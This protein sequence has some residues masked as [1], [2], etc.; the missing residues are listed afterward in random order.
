MAFI[1]EKDLAYCAGIVDGEGYLGFMRRGRCF[2]VR[3]GVGNTNKGLIDW[4]AE[5]FDASVYVKHGPRNGCKAQWN[6]FW[7]GPRAGSFLRPIYPYLRA[8]RPQ[9]KII[10][11]YLQ[12]VQD[13]RA[14]LGV[15][16]YYRLPAWL[17]TFRDRVHSKLIA[18]NARGDSW[19]S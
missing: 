9:A 6:V 13:N 2:G 7:D 11:S 18:L 15:K 8:K 16:K 17:E 12:I 4:L 10:L 5:T 3:V 14:R 19:R 1:V